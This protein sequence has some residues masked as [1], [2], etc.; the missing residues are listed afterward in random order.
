LRRSWWKAGLPLAFLLTLAV[1]SSVSQGTVKIYGSAIGV[2]VTVDCNPTGASITWAGPGTFI[3][4][5]ACP[6]PAAGSVPADPGYVTIGSGQTLTIDAS[7]GPVTVES[8]GAGVKFAGGQL[9]TTGTDRDHTVTFNNDPTQAPTWNGL[10]FTVD[11]NDA[12]KKGSGFLSFVSI[13]RAITAITI[14]SGATTNPSGSPYGL[15]VKNS[16]IEVSFFDGINATNTPISVSGDGT[17]TFGTIN[18]IGSRGIDLKFTNA[19][20]LSGAALNV[21]KVTFGSSVPFGQT[22]A[23]TG[24]IGNE[25]ILA[26]FAPAP[27][28]Q[29]PASITNN[30]IFRAGNFGIHVVGSD[31]LTMQNNMVVCSGTGSATPVSSCSGTGLKYSAIDLEGVTWDFNNGASA[32][33]VTPARASGNLGYNNGIDAIAFSGSASQDVTWLTPVA[34]ATDAS[35]KQLGYLINGSLDTAG[36]NLAVGTASNPA[37]VKVKTGGISLSGGKLTATNATF[38]SLRDTI[39]VATCP[40]VFAGSCPA[41]LPT[42]EWTGLNLAGGSSAT[43][44][45]TR[46][47]YA[48]KAV[49]ISGGAAS[50]TASDGQSYGLILTDSSIGPTFSDGVFAQKTPIFLSGD[51]FVCP[52]N[53][54]L[55]PS[56]QNCI[57]P[58]AG[59]HAINADFS[60]ASPHL[61]G[62][63]KVT[64]TTFQGSVNEAI[65]GTGLGGQTVSITGTVI[66]DAGSYG[67]QLQAANTLTLQNNNILTSGTASPKHSAIYL[68]G[69]SADFGDGTTSH[70]SGNT[71]SGNGLNAIVFHGTATTPTSWQTV[72]KNTPKLG[73]LLDGS[74]QVDGNL[75]LTNDVAEALNGGITVNGGLLNATN[76]TFTSL[77]DNVNGVPTCGTVFVP[78]LPQ[79]STACLAAAAGDWYGL[80]LDIS[81]KNNLSD[82]N[83]RFATNGISLGPSP[84]TDMLLQMTNTSVGSTTGDGVS[85]QSASISVTGGTFSNIGQHGIKTDFSDA[86]PGQT[87][88]I[89]GV[90]FNTMIGREAIFADSLGKQ[91]VAVTS[92]RIDS[93]GASG[94][95]LQAANNPTLSGNTVT[96]SG[97]P[98]VLNPAAS[99]PAIYLN[100]VVGNFTT[101]ITGN[102]GAHNG[103]NAI[104]F[105]GEATDNLI[106]WQTARVSSN[107]DKPPALG[108]LLDDSLAVDGSLSLA[109]GD[110]VKVGRGAI[111]LR[112]GT[113][114]ADNTDSGSRKVLTSLQDN[115]IGVVA[116]PSSLLPT[117]SPANP[118]AKE[119]APGD[120]TG[121]VLTHDTTHQASGAFVN[122]SIRYADTGISIDS[123][124]RSTS[125][126]TVFG[127][128]VSHSSI[129]SSNTDGINAQNTAVS[130]TASTVFDSGAH[131]LR[132]NLGSA[133]P[134]TPVLVSSVQF[135][136]AGA[137]AILGESLGLMPVWITDSTIRNAARYGVRLEGSDQLVLRN[138]VISR[139]GGGPAAGAGRYS[140]IYLNGVA[141]DFAR[142]VRGNVGGGNGLDAI[143]LHGTI[144]GDLT[145][146]TPR[147]QTLPHPLGYLLD[148]G[149]T[150]QSGNLVVA[151][152]DV[153]KTLGG[154]ITLKG[155]ALLAV[156]PGP[157]IRV[158]TS[159]KD[160]PT[161][162]PPSGPPLS[163]ADLED[164]AAVSCPS[165][166]ASACSPSPADWGGLVIT[167]GGHGQ[168]GN[169][170]VGH[171]L[172]NYADTGIS[173]DS[174][175]I[176]SA[177][178]SNFRLIVFGGTAISNANR[179]GINTFDT[180]ILVDSTSIRT[181]GGHGVLAS[182]FSPANCA[183]IPASCLS[184]S[185]TN[186]QITKTGKDGIIANGLTGQPTLISNNAIGSPAAANSG[187]GTSGITLIG[188]DKLILLRNAVYNSGSPGSLAYPAIYLSSVKGDFK[189]AISGNTGINGGLNALVFHGEATG[190]VSWLT[191]GSTA[192]NLLGYLLDGPLTIDG[193]F[194]THASD[195]VKVLGGAVTVKGSLQ[196]TGTTFTS[197]HDPIGPSACPSVLVRAP[198]P[199]PTPLDWGGISVGAPSLV[200]GGAIHYA[201]AGVSSSGASL[202]VNDPVDVAHI[203]GDAFTLNGPNAD[204]S[205]T[206]FA[207]HDVTGS[208]IK[209]VNAAVTVTK[210][211]FEDVHGDAISVSGASQDNTVK[212]S[213]FS[214]IGGVS[215]NLLSGAGTPPNGIIRDIF[216]GPHRAL[217]MTTRDVSV[218]CSS[219]KFGDLAGGAAL[220][221]SDNDLLSAPAVSNMNPP[222]SIVARQNLWHADGT[223]PDANQTSGSVDS[224][225]HLTS[226][227]PVLVP[228]PAGTTTDVTNSIG[229][230]DVNKDA[231]LPLPLTAA[232]LTAT[233]AYGVSDLTFTLVFNRRMLNDPNQPQKLP[234][235]W[236]N[237]TGNPLDPTSHLV[238][239]HW[240]DPGSP[241]VWVATYQLR[242]AAGGL[243]A[244]ASNGVNHVFVAGGTSCVPDGPNQ[245]A[246][247][248]G[249]FKVALTPSAV[250][251]SVTPM[252]NP[253][254]GSAVVFNA[255][256]TS[257][258]SP[259]LDSMNPDLVHTASIQFGVIPALVGVMPSSIHPSAPL[260]PTRLTGVA[261]ANVKLVSPAI[262]AGTYAVSAVFPGDDQYT[263]SVGVGPLTVKAAPTKT[264]LTS[265]PTPGATLASLDTVTLRANVTID[266]SQVLG[267]SGP[268]PTAADGTVAF[269]LANGNDPCSSISTSA[270]GVDLYVDCLTTFASISG[271]NVTATFVP[272]VPSSGLPINYLTSAT[273]VTGTQTTLS[274]TAN[275]DGVTET[276]TA[277]VSPNPLADGKILFFDSSTVTQL[278][279][280]VQLS[281]GTASCSTGT[282]YATLASDNLQAIY[283]PDGSTFAASTGRLTGTTTSLATVP[284]DPTSVNLTATV[285][286][287]SGTTAPSDGQVLFADGSNLPIACSNA[288]SLATPNQVALG[289]GGVASKATCSATFAGIAGKAKLVASYVGGTGFAGSQGSVTGTNTALTVNPNPPDNSQLV[290]LTAEVSGG[291]P[292]DVTDRV[293]FWDG[294]TALADCGGSSGQ[295]FG[296]GGAAANQAKCVTSAALT[297]GAHTLTS[298]YAPNNDTYASSL[299]SKAVTV[300][301][302]TTTSLASIPVDTSTVK[303]QA[304]VTG[305]GSQPS[306]GH[307][308]VYKK[309]DGSG[310]EVDAAHCSGL[311]FDVVG[312][313]TQTTFTCQTSYANIGTQGLQAVYTSA[314]TS[315]F[316]N[317][318]GS[319]TGTTTSLDS[320]TPDPPT[321]AGTTIAASVAS[322][323]TPTGTLA[324]FDTVGG[325]TSAV[326]CTNH[327][328]SNTVTLVAGSATCDTGALTGGNIV[329]TFTAIYQDSANPQGFAASEAQQA[330]TV[331]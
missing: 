279:G 282:T 133:L 278:C 229:L 6:V 232:N 319:L 93:A 217:K 46:I 53:T 259:V 258:T 156:S 211:S 328:G 89:D 130:V 290:T 220:S 253:N 44:A 222:G 35:G 179:D 5:A 21:D 121:L 329:H 180:P 321:T 215:I 69:V 201:Q 112:A 218:T 80:S 111:T 95:Y 54:A 257:G 269:L 240:L 68:N 168:T 109:A 56:N 241:H 274:T 106:T 17:G 3:L 263:P 13:Q 122:T 311:S 47:A 40:S 273:T 262:N 317:S 132:V 157:G 275:L 189:N 239:G 199:G 161:P 25:A 84:A 115:S 14:D 251:A 247:A 177:D 288:V 8:Q 32:P 293:I 297:A 49:L 15:D 12:T 137:E 70:I 119:P 57:G 207:I 256:V 313:V 265:T 318:Q 305:T 36:H 298:T 219:L 26:S 144:F 48:T 303:L 10:N 39:G 208:G 284:V 276:L 224:T 153:V 45:G 302:H 58:S 316:T 51:T 249:T 139:S 226:Q 214:G 127:L 325:T 142:N 113:V 143:V 228:P 90:N 19:P 24:T 210:G 140:A 81:G 235:L 2:P 76:S 170:F 131:G 9:T 331:S 245:M 310:G 64:S 254:Y 238:P 175:P 200:D 268:N 134:S 166:F 72:G 285:N 116:C 287:A 242:S 221:A 315:L 188:A 300:P 202:T 327:S 198:C 151:S 184:L 183:P 308:T 7:G 37:V 73:Y 60:G 204:S 138:N 271:Q 152:N 145:W 167:N 104:A 169:G 92:N 63:I 283:A 30:T 209:A 146:R 149:I 205:F 147:N 173:I 96:N 85:A 243:P 154:L 203:A 91:T 225:A 233:H 192:G 11:P 277:A 88:T 306:L 252:A 98:P 87:L 286:Q 102:K 163:P 20:L 55:Q 75:N 100:G 118:I 227:R 42:S 28:R 185:L 71:G 295:A 231:G 62:G 66:K 34:N 59:D 77:R 248:M 191:P 150:L 4:P 29:Q 320:F 99:Y 197:L 186:L 18:N 291:A 165:V 155:G 272:N 160:N 260:D 43:I 206:D 289:T 129:A 33:P 162:A 322:G 136:G 124:A 82:S 61:G 326:P 83:V 255:L 187:A 280:P 117:C 67:I 190:D 294:T 178:R 38:T 52:T 78:Q 110:I 148:G 97:N 314:D 108:Y 267:G 250:A 105:H 264:T 171:A 193:T 301:T 312:L 22:T 86:V 309:T 101:K 292:K 172:I 296:T 65:L 212:D 120:W 114:K 141:A 299:D 126:S 261:T 216:N 182:F 266:Q 158:F 176:T 79:P 246:V 196:S 304:T 128:V 1:T 31:Q 237:S 94:I 164:M 213:T 195:V 74:L 27:G 181:V 23:V 234:K 107:V 41:P 324:F 174:G 244:T 281:A 307:L 270:A 323:S 159:F 194:T 230:T 135:D 123:A 330:K 236:F 125:G 16:G 50:L 103:L 223:A